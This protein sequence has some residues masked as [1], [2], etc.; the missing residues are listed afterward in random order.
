VHARTPDAIKQVAKMAFDSCGSEL[1]FRKIAAVT[2]LTV[3]TSKL[4]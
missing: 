1:S 4:I 2:D 3:D